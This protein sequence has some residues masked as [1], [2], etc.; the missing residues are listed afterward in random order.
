MNVNKLKT[1]SK[2]NWEALD[3]K[4]DEEIDTSD[5]PLLDEEFFANAEWQMPEQPMVTL[6]VDPDV[7]EWFK[8][9]GGNFRHR[10]NAA[11]RIYAQAHKEP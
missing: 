4:T 7:L 2:T 3:Q 8:D 6:V 1:H 9:Q 10:I 11:L 5:I